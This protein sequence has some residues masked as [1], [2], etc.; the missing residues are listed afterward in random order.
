MLWSFGA[1]EG[2]K[3]DAGQINV[4]CD[5]QFDSKKNA[6]KWMKVFD[7]EDPAPINSPMKL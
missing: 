4:T 6:Q 7:L 1:L 3:Q 2:P 5:S